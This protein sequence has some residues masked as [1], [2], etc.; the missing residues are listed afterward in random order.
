M[1]G[2][3]GILRDPGPGPANP[4]DWDRDSISRN[5][6]DR[7]KNLRDSPATKIPRDNES[8]HSGQESRSVP[9]RSRCPGILR[10][11]NLAWSR[12]DLFKNIFWKRAYYFVGK[13]LIISFKFT[14]VLSSSQKLRFL[15]L[16]YST[17]ICRDLRDC[18]AG[19]ESRSVP[20]LSVFRPDFRPF[21]IF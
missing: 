3:P 16:C 7:D 12:E 10:D 6:R 20:T 9:G 4:R 8:R 2:C 15:F 21:R 14:K 13:G 17:N 19:R 1:G 11:A 18:P 5:S